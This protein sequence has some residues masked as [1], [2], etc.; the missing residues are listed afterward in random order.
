MVSYRWYMFCLLVFLV[1]LS[2]LAKWLAGK[3]PLRKPKH[4]E[5]FIFIKPRPKNVYY[6]L[7]LLYCSI[8]CIICL[9]CPPALHDIFRTPIARYSL[10]VLKVLLNNN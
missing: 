6:F 2:V 8:V 10:F 7:G 3:T 5:G 4:C 1:K 9:S